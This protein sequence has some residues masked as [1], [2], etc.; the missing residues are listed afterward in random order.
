MSGKAGPFTDSLSASRTCSLTGD[1][2]VR[3]IPCFAPPPQ[4]LT[5]T[6]SRAAVTATRTMPSI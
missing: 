2:A 3:V 1:G 5:R 4:A 6:T